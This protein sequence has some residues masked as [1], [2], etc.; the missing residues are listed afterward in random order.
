MD[1]LSSNSMLMMEKSMSYLWTKQAAILD[2]ISNAETANYKP[3][4]VTFEKSLTSKLEKAG[5]NS[6]P[7]KT[8]RGVLETAEFGV[9]EYQQST[10]L[11]DN[12]VNITDEMTEMMRNA[13]QQQYVLQSINSNL[14]ILRT[15]I[16]GQ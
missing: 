6:K 13:Y 14:S 15:A 11:D 4:V 10:R 12:G 9:T 2:N 3:K 1:F 7:K 8:V 16:N 5:S